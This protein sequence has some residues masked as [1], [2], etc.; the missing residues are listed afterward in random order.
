M[1]CLRDSV[2][3]LRG[4]PHGDYP[5]RSAFEHGRS[6]SSRNWSSR[7]CCPLCRGAER[8][9][10]TRSRAGYGNRLLCRPWLHGDDSAERVRSMNYSRSMVIRVALVAVPTLAA[11]GLVVLLNALDATGGIVVVAY[12]AVA[13]AIG[14][15]IG[16]SIDRLPGGRPSQEAHIS[17]RRHSRSA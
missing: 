11:I 5:F 13:V 6:S 16:L 9:L 12:T 1:F 15:A 2:A 17:Q 14:A 3:W 4:V 7:R 10:R 8:P